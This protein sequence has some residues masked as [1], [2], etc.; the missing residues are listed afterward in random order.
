M[1]DFLEIPTS[2]CVILFFLRKKWSQSRNYKIYF[3]IKQR[4]F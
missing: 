2:K 3:D 1:I 4:H